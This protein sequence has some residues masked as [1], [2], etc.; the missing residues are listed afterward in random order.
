M[1]VEDCWKYPDG[2]PRP[3]DGVGLRWRARWRERGQGKSRSFRTRASAEKYLIHQLANP[4]KPTDEVLVRDLVQ[5]WQDAK[6]SLAPKT[7]EAARLAGAHVVDRWGALYA[8]EVAPSQVRVWLGSLELSESTKRH[9]FLCLR[10]A[11]QLAV[12]DGH[13][14]RNPCVGIKTPQSG[15][16]E[17]EF[18][19][20]AELMALADAAGEYRPLVLLLGTCGL[21]IGEA[22]GLNVGDVDPERKRLRVRPEISKSPRGRDVPVPATTLAALDLDRVKK[23]P[24]FVGERGGRLSANWW[25]RSRF[26]AAAESV[27]REGMDPH[28]L[29]HTAASLAIASGADVLMVQRMLGH[30]SAAVTLGVYGHLWPSGL[31]DVADRMEGLIR[32]TL[33]TQGVSRPERNPLSEGVTVTLA[34]PRR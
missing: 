28:E 11:L 23:A 32:D 26:A 17:P 13:L 8:S 14:E 7:R 31:D 27:G 9:I 16:R 12:D 3:R 5:A 10:G 24:L 33:V 30:R 20:A 29:R 18:M 15:R 2:S 1:A 25:R 21:R 34:E 4:P 22:C 6:R 19:S